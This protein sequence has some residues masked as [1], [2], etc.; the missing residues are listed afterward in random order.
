[1]S[2]PTAPPPGDRID[3]WLWRAR[4]FKTRS[5]AAQAVA[6]GLRINGRRV[7]KPGAT[8]RPGDVLTFAR[9]R[10]IFVVEIAALGDRRGPP[11]EARTLFLDR[12]TTTT[13]KAGPAPD[14][15]ERQALR[16]LRRWDT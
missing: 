2:D 5:L 12:G 16:R 1:M 4:F 13:P 10:T 3:K 9:G 14:S 8:V 7:E 6:C 11:R 15:R